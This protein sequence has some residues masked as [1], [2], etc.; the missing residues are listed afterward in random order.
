MAALHQMTT[1]QKLINYSNCKVTE[2]SFSLI[3]SACVAG[4]QLF[5]EWNCCMM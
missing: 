1:Q 5:C 3:K 4:M 2:K